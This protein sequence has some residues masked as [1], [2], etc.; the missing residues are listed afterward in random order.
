[1]EKLIKK[2]VGCSKGYE[3]YGVGGFARDL[4]L[5]R[6][7]A[8]IDLAVGK[9]AQKFAKNTASALA[10]KLVVL[11]DLNKVYRIILKDKSIVSNI[12]ISLFDGKNIEEDLKNRDFTVNA[13][14][15]NIA[16]FKDYKRNMIFADKRCLADLKNKT[17][18]TVSKAAFKKD[19]LRMLRAFRFMAETGFK[20]TPETLKQIKSNAKLIKQ[21]APE[22][23]KNEFFRILSVPNSC[24]VLKI[25]DKSGLLTALFCEITKM[26]KAL[27]KYYYHPGGLFQ[28]SFEAMEAAENIL[29][30]LKKYFPDNF[31][32]L[33][34]HFSDKEKYSENVTGA[35]LLKFAALF[36]DNAK[37]ETAKKEGNKMRFFGHEL[38]GAEKI[39]EIMK[40][41]KAGKK[42]TAVI[43]FLIENHMRPSTLTKNNIVTDKAALKFFR[44]AGENTP[45][46][47]LLS[48]SDWHSYKRLKVFSPNEL[49][50]QEKS[51][52]R[53]ISMYYK[54]KN[55]KP[56]P[57]ITNGNIIMKRFK[58]K[59]GPWL[60]DL[61]EAVTQAQQEGKISTGKEALKLISSK[62][63]SVKKKYKL[64]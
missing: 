20:I 55:T 21:A 43:K 37:P 11:D 54:V 4:Y 18:N 61:L 52:R 58:L 36:H 3:V 17:L 12:D 16:Y 31:N 1:M 38:L 14:A 27:K 29:N 60:K 62:L 42:E 40:T 8:D 6:R 30:D 53:L 34:E 9:D 25:M 32:E 51:V 50:N 35:N 15:F 57:K 39:E 7:H 44:D 24:G 26:K 28:H 45:D 46:L 2:I 23:I 33:E 47:L 48:M 59:P 13:A 56:L 10:A 63:S 19:P 5:K 41:L 64:T 49:K 22:R